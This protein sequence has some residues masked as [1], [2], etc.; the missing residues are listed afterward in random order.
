M[1]RL[2][3]TMTPVVVTV[4]LAP[5]LLLCD[6]SIGVPHLDSSSEKSMW[7]SIWTNKHEVD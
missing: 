6:E 3:V 7:R 4:A 1:R 5:A 2:V